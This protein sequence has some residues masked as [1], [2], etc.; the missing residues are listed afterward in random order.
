MEV[1]RESTKELFKTIFFNKRMYPLLTNFFMG[2]KK[3][4]IIATILEYRKKLRSAWKQFLT[5]DK[6]F[7]A[8]LVERCGVLLED[9][10]V[11]VVLKRWTRTRVL[12]LSWNIFVIRKS[13]SSHL[14]STTWMNKC[15]NAGL[16]TFA[17][18]GMM[19]SHMHHA[20][21][22]HAYSQQHHPV[23][24]QY[25]SAAAMVTHTLAQQMHAPGALGHLGH[26]LPH[27]QWSESPGNWRRFCSESMFHDLLLVSYLEMG[28]GFFFCTLAETTLYLVRQN[29]FLVLWCHVG[30]E[31]VLIYF[32]NYLFWQTF[33]YWL[34]MFE[35][36]NKPLSLIVYVAIES[37]LF[38]SIAVQTIFH[39]RMNIM[40]IWFDAFFLPSNIVTFSCQD[41]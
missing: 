6:F 37:F 32:A 20:Q 28:N 1:P 16:T 15:S 25:P 18:Q 26:H 17:S 14:F 10:P 36:W 22:H 38:L 27:G 12:W 30:S 35:V 33:D 29:L 3:F 39:S 41:Q 11:F 24:S 40:L 23:Q 21:Q 5:K 13:M 31:S 8:T 19:A 7:I 2:K 9:A 4:L 34:Y